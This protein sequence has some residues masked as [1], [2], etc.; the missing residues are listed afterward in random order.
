MKFIKL[1]WNIE[2]LIEL[3][4]LFIRSGFSWNS[5]LWISYLLPKIVCI[6]IF[7]YPANVLIKYKNIIYFYWTIGMVLPT[8]TL[9]SF[10]ALIKKHYFI[11]LSVKIEIDQ[12]AKL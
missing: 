2:S 12:Y 5:L 7:T 6:G 1:I 9:H 10:K 4:K 11:E 3:L 8:Y